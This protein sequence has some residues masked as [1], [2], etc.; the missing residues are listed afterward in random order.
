MKGRYCTMNERQDQIMA[1]I[2][3]LKMLLRDTDYEVTKYAEGL[4]ACTTQKEIQAYRA[5]FMAEHGEVI[6]SRKTWRARI[7]ELEAELDGLTPADPV[8]EAAPIDA[9][10]DTGTDDGTDTE[11]D[12]EPDT[13]T[14]PGTDTGTGTE[15]PAETDNP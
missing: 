10:P 8:A 1:E 11:P 12:T 6:E 2:T 7:N 13:G 14:E 9:E 4:T 3:A 15:E 5:E